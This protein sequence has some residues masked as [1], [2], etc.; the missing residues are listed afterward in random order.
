MRV[1][2][3]GRPR[4]GELQPGFLERIRTGE[5]LWEKEEEEQRAA[6]GPGCR[7][8]DPE[9]CSMFFRIP[10]L[11]PGYIRYLQVGDSGDR[12]DRRLVPRHRGEAEWQTGPRL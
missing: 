4:G 5:A 10:R 1:V 6:V 11:T 2:R 7:A 3:L 9:G 8:A 12:M